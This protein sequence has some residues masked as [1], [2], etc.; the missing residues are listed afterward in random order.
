MKIKLFLMLLLLAAVS[1]TTAQQVAL[2]TNLLYD[3]TLTPNLGLEV[4]MGARRSAQVVYGFNNWAYGSDAQGDRKV[5]HWLVMPEY[6]WWTCSVFNGFFVGVHGMGGQ[7][8][9]G[10]VN[11]VLPGAFFG[12]A[13]LQSEV[14][15]A[16]F[17]GGFVGGG[18]TAGYQFILSK[19]W[20]L[21]L[22][23]GAGYDYVWYE[24]FPCADCG[25]RIDR[26]HTNYVG[27]TKLGV[28]MMYVF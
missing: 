14:R 12:G 9:A 10:N 5:C 27:L 13:N 19:H 6:R 8:N 15:D 1:G 18:L 20:N 16:R 7:F 3:A 26:G 2:K 17:E 24:K 25:T 23:A 4:S 28:C 21:E 11:M 22:E